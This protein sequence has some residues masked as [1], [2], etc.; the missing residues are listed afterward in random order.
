MRIVPVYTHNNQLTHW[1]IPVEELK[2]KNLQTISYSTNPLAPKEKA[3]LDALGLP[4]NI[5][6]TRVDGDAQEWLDNK[7]SLAERATIEKLD[8][9][10]LG[11]QGELNLEGFVNLK[12]LDCSNNELTDLDIS[13]CS[14]LKYLDASNN[15]IKGPDF[16][17]GSKLETIILNHNNLTYFDFYESL[18]NSL[19]NLELTA[20]QLR[21]TIPSMLGFKGYLD[22]S[23]YKELEN[24]NVGINKLCEVDL[25]NNVKLKNL[26]CYTNDIKELGVKHLTDLEYLI[27]YGNALKSL[28]YSNLEKLKELNCS[29]NLLSFGKF[30]ETFLEKLNVKNC[31]NLEVLDCAENYLQELD[32]SNLPKLS[33]V[34]GKENFF[35]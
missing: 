9:S 17:E 34:L 13:E 1:D 33:F 32:I 23:D 16:L 3:R 8:I 5:C 27:C 20:N 7:Y 30:D 11:L 29:R 4:D 10:N 14:K 18:A 35:Y 21:G 26:L 22:V 12:R 15:Q 24:L 25:T 28:D 2:S 19:K 31:N 6:K